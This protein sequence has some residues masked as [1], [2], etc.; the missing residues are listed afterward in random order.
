[1][2]MCVHVCVSVSPCPATVL[3]SEEGPQ[4]RPPAGLPPTR[5]YCCALFPLSIYPPRLPCLPPAL[6]PVSLKASTLHSF[7]LSQAG[8]AHHNLCH[9]QTAASWNVPAALSSDRVLTS[10][11]LGVKL[12]TQL[13]VI[14]LGNYVPN[15]PPAPHCKLPPKCPVKWL[16][17]SHI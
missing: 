9:Y 16:H 14:V 17:N 6:H 13:P 10:C 7:M 15:F 8:R 12:T 1:M 3:E 5:G 11:R 4:G 2:C